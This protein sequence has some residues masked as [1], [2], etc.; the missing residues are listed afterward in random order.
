[1]SGTRKGAN[2]SKP[3]QVWLS[4][5][6]REQLAELAKQERRSMAGQVRHLIA[7]AADTEREAA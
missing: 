5:A 6:E 2:G 4:A 3:L 7:Q 1:M